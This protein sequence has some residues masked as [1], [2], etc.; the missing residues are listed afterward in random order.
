MLRLDENAGER[1]NPFSDNASSN[2]SLNILGGVEGPLIFGSSTAATARKLL[3]KLFFSSSMHA[4]WEEKI[5]IL[6]MYQH[7][8]HYI[9]CMAVAQVQNIS[10]FHNFFFPGGNQK[11]PCLLLKYAL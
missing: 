1:L 10:V 3:N 7:E 9:L 11:L 8:K 6:A 4:S 5:H 2:V